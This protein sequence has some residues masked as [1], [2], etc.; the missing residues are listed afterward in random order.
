M[1]ELNTIPTEEIN[2]KVIIVRVDL[3]VPVDSN[4]KITDDT[5]I[6]SSLP[7]I[8]YLTNHGGKIIIISHFGRPEPCF[9]SEGNQ[10]KEINELHR[11]PNEIVDTYSANGITA[12]KLNYC[13]G[14]IVT[15][16]I[17]NMINGELI[18]LEN[19]RFYTGECLNEES[20]AQKLAN[21]ADIFVMDAFGTSHRKH[22]STLGI[23]NFVKTCVTG[24]LMEKEIYYL[25][26]VCHANTKPLAAIIGG[27]KISTKLRVIKSLM[28]KCNKIFIGG[29][30]ANT[31]L[32]AKGFDV[33]SSLVEN[34]MLDE[35][36]EIEDAAQNSNVELLLPIDVVISKSYSNDSD[37]RI[38]NV[39]DSC[40]EWMILDIG[41]KTVE[42]YKE[43]FTDCKTIIWNG[44]MGVFE[45]DNFSLGTKEIAYNL[46]ERASNDVTVIVG[47]GDSVS[48][49]N[50]YNIADKITHISTGGGAML[51][52]LS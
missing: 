11:L 46:S 38:I 2:G 8:K 28:N 51:E 25:N 21:S 14:D 16:A 6:R 22:A 41:P 50:K 4:G 33:G 48:A 18:I 49:V 24:F 27:S 43:K 35:V 36:K 34:N 31:F 13:I 20:F 12:K 17:S 47:G 40:D 29:G 32:K 5:R 15:K 44:P 3:N 39:G 1:L 9:D 23:Q 26:L 19:V 45:L 10:C 52:Y 30:M 42:L 37:H 7:T